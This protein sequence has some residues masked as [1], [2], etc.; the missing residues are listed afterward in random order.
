MTSFIAMCLMANAA[1][2]NSPLFNHTDPVRAPESV[3]IESENSLT[4]K[5]EFQSHQ[6]C[7]DFIWVKEPQGGDEGE[8]KIYFWHKDQPGV[9]TSPS[10]LQVGVKLWMPDMG[11]GSQ[12][13][14]VAQTSSGVYDATE[15]MFVMGGIWEIQFQLKDASG[16][17]VEMQKTTYQVH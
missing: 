12:K 3:A 6:L 4:C 2:G 15:I 13:V 9:F 16:N 17:V 14:K 10:D 1:C 11:H 5:M 7:A 8:M